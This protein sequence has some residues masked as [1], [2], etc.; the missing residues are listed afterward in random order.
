MTHQD[1]S[2]PGTGDELKVTAKNSDSLF[3]VRQDTIGHLQTIKDTLH[4]NFSE[5]NKTEITT[6]NVKQAPI[7]G[8]DTSPVY[9]KSRASEINYYYTGENSIHSDDSKLCF[10][11][12]FLESVQD[13][14]TE[15]TSEIASK[16]KEGIRKPGNDFKADWMLPVLLVSAIVF[17]TIQKIPVNL[18]KSVTNFFLIKGIN[19]SGSRDNYKIY[20]FQST[21]L[22]FASLINISLWLYVALNYYLISFPFFTDFKLWLIILGLLITAISIRH[23]IIMF[24]GLISEQEAVF[25]E[26]RI[27]VSDFCRVTGAAGFFLLILIL[28][29]KSFATGIFLKTGFFI[30]FACYMIRIIKL[31]LIFINRHI[32]IL[33]L[34]LYLCALEILPFAV[35]I[36]LLKELSK[37]FH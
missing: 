22:N 32:S 11:F 4:N 36:K 7:T 13:F 15:R 19:E 8:K 3:N 14:R 16:L 28:Y 12:S 31:L 24:T 9:T 29:T 18:I 34:I 5:I 35:L 33:Y 6:L 23:L 1:I 10:P 20:N 27:I 17:I 25:S 37:N 21:A 26:Y 2:K 30:F